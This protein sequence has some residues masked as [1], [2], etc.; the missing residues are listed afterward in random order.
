MVELGL[1]KVFLYLG[2]YCGVGT[3]QGVFYLGIYGGAF[4][5]FK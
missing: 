4:F 3:L 2:I 5:K 1:F